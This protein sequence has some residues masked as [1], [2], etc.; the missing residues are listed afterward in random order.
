MRSEEEIRAVYE[1][2]EEEW[3]IVRKMFK[4]VNNWKSLETQIEEWLP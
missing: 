4:N 3:Q 1:K 2:A